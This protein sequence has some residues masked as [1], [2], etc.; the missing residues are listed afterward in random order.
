[1][2]LDLDDD[3]DDWEDEGTQLQGLG[4]TTH[5]TRHPH[6]AVITRK[7]RTRVVGVK[8][9]ADEEA[10][11]ANALATAKKCRETRV[12]NLQGLAEDLDDWQAQSE[13]R[14]QELSEKY[15]MKV[16]EVRRC[17]QASSAFKPRR[18]VSV[19]NAKISA[20]VSRLNKGLCFLTHK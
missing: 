15:G 14:A 8:R 12:H 18:K 3:D 10:A 9:T 4:T 20:L 2:D 5:Q 16:K 1:M 19:Y 6:K 13:E 11:R 17:L 7:R